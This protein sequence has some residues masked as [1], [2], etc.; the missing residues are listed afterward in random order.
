MKTCA[1]VI[2]LAIITYN[3]RAA[4]ADITPAADQKPI[5]QAPDDTKS[6]PGTTG[7]ILSYISVNTASPLD[8]NWTA[9]MDLIG[10]TETSHTAQ[11]NVVLP[12]LEKYPIENL[13][14]KLKLLNLHF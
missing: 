12:F 2:L 4:D 11:Y 8:M 3:A 10:D 6:E 14:I 13:E 7:G 5:Y 9:S 1:F